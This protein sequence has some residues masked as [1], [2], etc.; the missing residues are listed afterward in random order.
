[1]LPWGVLGGHTGG[2]LAQYFLIYYCLL[3]PECNKR[4]NIN[5]RILFMIP[6]YAYFFMYLIV[7]VTANHS[8]EYVP[9]RWYFFEDLNQNLM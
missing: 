7:S 4:F 5:Y 1:M 2:R 8:N 3:I 6:F 9:F